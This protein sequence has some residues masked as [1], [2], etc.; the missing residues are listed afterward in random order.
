MSDLNTVADHDGYPFQ[1]GPGKARG[2]GAGRNDG[3]RRVRR[4]VNWSLAALVVGVG[5]TTAAIAHVVPTHTT[6]VVG[7]SSTAGGTRTSGQAPTLSGPVASST[8]SGVVV[9][10][11]GSGTGSV[12][13]QTGTVAGSSVSRDS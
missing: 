4:H 12:G 6:T 9:G 1:P 7:T 5:A 2:A 3:L 8:A 11:P 13:A 10:T